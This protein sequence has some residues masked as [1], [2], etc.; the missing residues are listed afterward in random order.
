VNADAYRVRGGRIVDRTVADKEPVLSDQQ[1]MELVALGRRIESHLGC[2]QDIEW[3]LDGDGMQIVQSRPIT[4]LFPVPDS[5]EGGNRVYISVGHGQM[6]TDPMTPLGISMWQLTS[7]AP[8]RAAGGRLYVDV[9]GRLSSPATRAATLEAVGRSDPLIRDALETVLARGDFIPTAV[10]DGPDVPPSGGGG[11]EPVETDPAIV[12]DLIERNRVSVAQLRREIR[13]RSGPSLFDFILDD[14][15]ELRALLFERGRPALMA[16][17]EATWW[18]NDNL[19]AWL[20]EQNPADV[21]SLAAPNN[22]TAEMGLALLDV[23][24]AIRPH[25][26]VIAFLRGAEGEDF[27]DHLIE[28]EGGK[29]ARDA[30]GAYL[31]AYGMRCIGEIDIARPRWRERPSALLP[32]ILANIE[33][34]EPG[35]R[36]RRLERGREQARMKE[37]ELLAR[38]RA[39]PGGA[40]KA[41][42][43]KRMIDR[44]R[45]FI[46]YREYPKYGMV[47]RYFIYRQALLAEAERLVED[48]VFQLVDDIAFLTFHELR[49]VVRTGQADRDLIARRR[50]EF[51]SFGKLTPPRVLTSEGEAL[52]GT[53][54]R[55]DVPA[56]AL[57]GLAVS[58]GTVEGR[59]RVVLDMAGAVLELGDILVTP[60]TDP[61][62]SPLFVTIAGLV[63]EVGGLMTHGSVIAR[64]YGLAAVVGVDRA[65]QRIQDGQRIR[66]DGTRG[67]VEILPDGTQHGA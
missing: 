2:P 34:F 24:D 40:E 7:P 28:L 21:L 17:F 41:E 6:L 50:E 18:L 52:N 45:T 38:V 27:L 67:L 19:A 11:P 16:G 25:P 58:G 44:L 51:R 12:A 53:Y 37:Q 43:T 47:S 54:R 61:S 5:D 62:W 39:L 29:E 10:G 15:D 56:G 35:E 49:D 57:V 3:C 30:I 26:A 59:A 8:M 33:K 60:H 64:E 48:R 13:T 4:T 31:D 9:T 14:L 36:E 22:V 42:E 23:A 65:T 46:G 32:M 63:T 66:V 1:V 55:D 20:G